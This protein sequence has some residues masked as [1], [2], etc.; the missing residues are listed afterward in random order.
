MPLLLL[1]SWNTT[2]MWWQLVVSIFNSWEVFST[3]VLPAGVGFNMLSST[4]RKAHQYHTRRRHL[5]MWMD[6]SLR[7]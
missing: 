3:A 4:L 1:S 7:T 5:R 6:Q 2:E